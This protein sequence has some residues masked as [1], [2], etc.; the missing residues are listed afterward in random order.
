VKKVVIIGGSAAGMMAAISAA[1]QGK[2]AEVTVLSA[3]AA[4]YRRPG[5]PA[6]ISGYISQPGQAGVFSNDVLARHNIK[7]LCPVEVTDINAGEKVVTYE[8]EGGKGKLAFD[9]AVI[10]TGGYPIIPKIK[11]A[12]KK[13]VCTFTTF[14]GAQQIVNAVSDADSAVVIG[15]GFI[16]LEI[17]EALM[18]KGLDVYFNVR[19]RILRK[20]VEPEVSEHLSRRFEREGLKML[21]GETISEIGGGESIQYV[22]HKGKKIP[23]KVVIMGTGMRPNV[24]LAEK[25]GIKLGQSGAIKVDSRMQTSVPNIY[26]AGDCAESPDLG[27]GRFVYSPV[28]SIGAMAGRIAG[29]NAAGGN[30]KTEGFLRAQADEILGLQIF[31]IG[32]S[33]T[34]AKEV[35]L[36]VKV[37]DLEVP[38]Q[39]E[40]AYGPKAFEMAKILTDENDRIVGAQLVTSRYGSQYA[41]QLYRA[42]LASE[43]RAEFLEHFISPRAKFAGALVQTITSTISVESFEGGESLTWRNA[44]KQQSVKN[45]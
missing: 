45:R 12:D 30:E 37:Q 41:W 3:D 11:G 2:S 44:P 27:T 35:G 10:A 24:A 23:T 42:V 25:C 40:K 15:A 28:G 29:R 4:A 21:M 14:E 16:A 9:S 38:E 39:V 1:R 33:T 8:G 20:I 17:A 43:D 32:H 6:L 22:V 26:A 7:L 34:T 5:I 31:S 19:S 13:G 18:H 36:K